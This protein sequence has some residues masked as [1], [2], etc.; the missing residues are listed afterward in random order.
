MQTKILAEQP[1]SIRRGVS[2]KE[3]QRLAI[4]TV[5]LA[6][7]I[8]EL[9]TNCLQDACCLYFFFHGNGA[10]D[11]VMLLLYDL[12]CRAKG[13]NSPQL[14]NEMARLIGLF[15]K[16]SHELKMYVVEYDAQYEQAAPEER[17]ELLAELSRKI[18]QSDSQIVQSFTEILKFL[19]N[20]LKIGAFEIPRLQ[21]PQ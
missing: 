18:E 10:Y 4:F 6:E 20:L 1:R 8:R 7:I 9:K 5:K 19:S 17:P 2:D 15:R 16:A 14:I 11:R 13:D 21:N 12:Y 3:Y